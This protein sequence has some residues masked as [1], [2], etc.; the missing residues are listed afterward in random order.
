M[1]WYRNIDALRI[2][3]MPYRMIV[4][5]GVFLTF[6]WIAVWTAM[7]RMPVQADLETRGVETTA[8][9]TDVRYEDRVRATRGGLIEVIEFQ[10]KTINGQ[11]VKDET[12]RPHTSNNRM[13]PGGT[14]KIT[15]LP[16]APTRHIS[17]FRPVF[18]DRGMVKMAL[19]FAS[20]VFIPFAYE[21]Y[22][23]PRGWRGPRLR[24]IVD[25]N[26]KPTKP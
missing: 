11:I 20:V 3:N 15:Y 22:R 12:T 7:V 4:F 26:A 1:F 8:T 5:G 2:F 18:A 19:I 10:F 13:Q 24:P 17:R 6:L 21:V 14:F 23:L 25:M 16:E 9:I